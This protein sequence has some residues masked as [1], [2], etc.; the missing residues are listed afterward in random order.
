MTL[1]HHPL[2]SA[3]RVTMVKIRETAAPA[4]GVLER[5]SFDAEMEQTVSAVGVTYDAAEVGGVPGWWCRP[6]KALENAAI[7]YLHGGA[8]ILG[9]ASAY[10][11]F[12]GQIAVRCGAAAFVP[13][14]RLAPEHPFP[15]AVED[16]RAA[17]RGLVEQGLTAIAL[18]GDSAGGGLTLILLSLITEEARSGAGLYPMCAA[19]L[20]PWTDLALSGPTLGVNADVDP[21]LTRAALASAARQYLGQQDSR[22]P[23]VSPLYGD[24]GGLPPITIHVG[25]AEILLDDSRRFAERV[26]A[27]GGAVSLNVWAGMPHV[28]ASNIG[29]LAAAEIALGDIGDFV[30]KCF[31]V[32]QARRVLRWRPGGGAQRRVSG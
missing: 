3:D 26:E 6:P 15:A 17:Y 2:S 11:N 22:N 20:S 25:E 10:R 1:V 13:D 16:A 7:L 12:V 8:Y 30:S 29:A 5:R 9:S 23:L 31:G 27:D 32:D 24:F 14:Y 18:V 28:F 19:V 4:K 21:F